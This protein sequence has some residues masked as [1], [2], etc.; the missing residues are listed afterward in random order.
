MRW[1]I[2]IGIAWR[3][4]FCH[5]SREHVCLLQ[6]LTISNLF[7]F[8]SF[9]PRNLQLQNGSLQVIYQTVV[10]D[11]LT[12][13]SK[14]RFIACRWASFFNS[15]LES[16]VRPTHNVSSLHRGG[17]IIAPLELG[18]VSDVNAGEPA[19]LLTSF[20]ALECGRLLRDPGVLQASGLSAA[21]GVSTGSSFS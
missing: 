1:S 11:F 4:S 5:T 12:K 15:N 6:N 16:K 10:L 3:W 19:R 8:G 9:L 21:L 7:I 2:T 17:D 20:D 13:N 14:F 18:I